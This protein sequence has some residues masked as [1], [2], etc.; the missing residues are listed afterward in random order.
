M[1]FDNVI[2]SLTSL[3]IPFSR[4][5]ALDAAASVLHRRV[6]DAIKSV[7][8]MYESQRQLRSESAGETYTS[9]FT[10]SSNYDFF[11]LELF[12]DN[13]D[14]NGADGSR[15]TAT[16][17]QFTQEASETHMAMPAMQTIS[18]QQEQL[19]VFDYPG[20]PEALQ[21]S[22]VKSAILQMRKLD[23]FIEASAKDEIKA[24]GLVVIPILLL[25]ALIVVEVLG[26]VAISLMIDNLLSSWEAGQAQARNEQ[27]WD[28]DIARLRSELQNQQRTQED[29]DKKTKE[30]N[31]KEDEKRKQREEKKERRRKR[32]EEKKERKDFYYGCVERIEKLNRD[33]GYEV[34]LDAIAENTLVDDIF[35]R[36]LQKSLIAVSSLGVAALP[37]YLVT[38]YFK[39]LP[40]WLVVGE[41]VNF[42]LD[43]SKTR[44]ATKTTPD[45]SGSFEDGV[46]IIERLVPSINFGRQ[47]FAH[48]LENEYGL[49]VSAEKGSFTPDLLPSAASLLKIA[50]GQAAGG[51]LYVEKHWMRS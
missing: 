22:E 46:T 23:A 41:W 33:R 40:P 34:R 16:L 19:Q 48:Y 1:N 27:R 30:I 28:E 24:Q 18:V 36:E 10:S 12:K 37:M 49:I 14:A 2:Q 3:P 43:T 51:R 31:E 9:V 4:E 26:P 47:G 17:R 21:S 42:K 6:N 29:Q 25:L 8:T 20:A 39:Q 44:P 5:S 13:I 45:V 38:V 50:F 35:L 32:D 11:P 7:A 15:W